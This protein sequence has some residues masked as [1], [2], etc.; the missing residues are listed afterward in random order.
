MKGLSKIIY[1]RMA[2]ERSSEAKRPDAGRTIVRYASKIP[3][4][5]DVM[6]IPCF[7][8]GFIYFYQ[9]EQRTL[10]ENFMMFFMIVGFLC[11]SIFTIM[12]MRNKIHK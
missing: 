11:D 8:V 4:Y 3:N 9:I 1:G 10:V 6:A 2:E 12:F 5:A 7:F